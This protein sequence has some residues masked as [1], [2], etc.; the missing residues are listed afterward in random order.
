MNNKMKG[1]YT[2]EAVVVMSTV[3][4]ALFAVLY[5]FMLLYQN[6]VIIYAASYGAQ[7]GARSW[8][9]TGISMDGYSY[10]YDTTLYSDVAELFDGGQT[11][12]KKKRV[13]DC[14]REK[15]KKSVINSKS[16]EIKV[17][18]DKNIFKRKVTVEINQ[19]VP[20]PFSGIAKYFNKGKPV[21]LNAKME[22]IVPAPEDFIRNIDYAYAWVTA[23]KDWIEDK[24]DESNSNVAKVIKG[25]IK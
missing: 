20:I 13:E 8:I 6:V 7:Q 5:A 4:I 23:F 24:A 21:S 25:L 2:I 1:S 22:A 18:F 15:L 9:N 10:E 3:L 17:D 16:A 11:D 12:E 19:K 14:V